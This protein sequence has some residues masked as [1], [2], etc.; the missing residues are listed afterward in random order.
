[1]ILKTRRAIAVDWERIVSKDSLFY[2]QE[3][4]KPRLYCEVE[5]RP[6]SHANIDICLTVEYSHYGD[7]SRKN[8][9][10]DGATSFDDFY[11]RNSDLLRFIHSN[12]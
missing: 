5:V 8:D 9:K 7:M 10:N 4:R 1:M 2:V 12:R 6:S 3:R 11:N